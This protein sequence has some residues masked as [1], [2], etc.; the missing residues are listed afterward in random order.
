MAGTDF[1]NAM[2]R[3]ELPEPPFGRLLG[4][5]LFDCGDGRF[6][7]SVQPQECHYNP[8]GCVHGGILST[9]LDSVMTAAVQ[10]ALPAG[11]GCM[12]LQINVNFLKP[13]FVRTGEVMAEGTLVSMGRQVATAE[14]RIIGV[15]GSVFA[16]GTTTCAV[17]DGSSKPPQAE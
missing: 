5:D 12:T 14:G 8:M 7:M 2:R 15:D 9:L 11:K 17:M 4:M 13:V 16:T 1:F 6:A 10:T 3:G